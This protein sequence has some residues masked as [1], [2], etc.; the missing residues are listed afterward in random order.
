MSFLP[1]LALAVQRWSLQASLSESEAIKRSEK[2][3]TALLSSVSH[4][5]RTPLAAISASASSL[6]MFQSEL[7]SDTKA[8]LLETIQE[9]CDR[10]DRVTTNLL[11]IGRIEG[12]LDVRKM[13]VI[14]AVEV[15]GSALARVRKLHASHRFDRD[16]SA[17]AAA[18][19]AD[20][21]LLEQVFL[22][23]LENAAVH[24]AAGTRVKVSALAKPRHL[25]IAIE[26][27]GAGIAETDRNR[28][29]QRFVQAGDD[30]R[31]QSGS[32]L[33]LSIARGFAERIGGS[34]HAC[35]AHPPL[36][37]ARIE[38]ELPLVRDQ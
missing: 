21:L 18:V 38:I 26:D 36:R 15:L 25:L 31:S 22:N 35:A 33:G 30:G 19:R 1:L 29:F 14:D 13:P 27:D 20:E 32:G 28:I 6:S 23:V 3:K 2:F 12:G 34:I 8:Q 9:Q 37:G 4:D 10:L 11:N 5:L 7:D 24:T 16:F 17:K